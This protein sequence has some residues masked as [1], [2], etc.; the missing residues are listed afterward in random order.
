MKDPKP[1]LIGQHRTVYDK[2]GDI[3]LVGMGARR[4]RTKSGYVGLTVYF[5]D[6]SA[7]DWATWSESR[8]EA[9]LASG[10]SLFSVDIA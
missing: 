4:W 2:V 9:V 3:Q 10:R 7:T 8:P 1:A 6:R 5:W